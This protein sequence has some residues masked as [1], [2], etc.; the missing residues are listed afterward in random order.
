MKVQDFFS[1]VQLGVGI[2]V[3]T[4]ILH[5]IGEFGVAPVERRIENIAIWLREE[6]AASIK[7]EDEE[8]ELKDIQLLVHIYTE[9]TNEYRKLAIGMIGVAGVLA[10]AL[11]IMSFVA[12]SDISILVALGLVLLSFIPAT[13]AFAYMLQKA[14]AALAPII[15]QVDGMERSMHA[16]KRWKLEALD[17]PLRGSS[18]EAWII[19]DPVHCRLPDRRRRDD[20][21][22][23][24]VRSFG[25]GRCLAARD[26]DETRSGK[27]NRKCAGTLIFW[28]IMR[29]HQIR[30]LTTWLRPTLSTVP[31]VTLTDVTLRASNR[32]PADR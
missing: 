23:E 32:V 3:G 15:R 8:E 22:G 21:F 2:H 16:K 13:I 11:A 4:A 7:L 27:S 14:T 9:Y 20:S 31:L 30:C 25:N 12:D 10:F 18:S 29:R 6:S 19:Q 24:I 26:P 1:I 28:D 5:L 17:A